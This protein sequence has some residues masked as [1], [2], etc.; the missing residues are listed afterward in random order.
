MDYGVLGF[1]QSSRIQMG[2]FI[3][4]IMALFF[5]CIWGMHTAEVE[6][7]FPF[8]DQ[9]ETDPNQYRELCVS[10]G[11]PNTSSLMLFSW[12]FGDG[13]TVEWMSIFCGKDSDSNLWL[14][15][16]ADLSVLFAKSFFFFLCLLVIR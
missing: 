2:M 1:P 11:N 10:P 8:T 6:I 7:V 12:Y 15:R 3:V 5:S 4:V 14:T 9:G 16:K 13:F